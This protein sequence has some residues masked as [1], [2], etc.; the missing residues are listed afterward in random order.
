MT[1]PEEH[2][3]RPWKEHQLFRI[4]LYEEGGPPLDPS[5]TL[6]IPVGKLRSFI[7]IRLICCTPPQF[8][9]PKPLVMV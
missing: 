1:A 2:T 6:I 3:Y 5:R 4:R 9:F 7:V 8:H